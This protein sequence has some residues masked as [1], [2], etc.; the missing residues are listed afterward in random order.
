MGG[1]FTTS[2]IWVLSG[3]LSKT[4]LDVRLWTL[5]VVAAI[6]LL[7]EVGAI[8]LATPT[9][10][11]M[12]PQSRFWDSR[13]LGSLWFGVE[14]GLGFRTR[15]YNFGPYLLAVLVLLLSPPFSAVVALSSGWA[16]GH[17][18]A[19]VV[20]LVPRVRQWEYLDEVYDEN[21]RYDR[22]LN[23]VAGASAKLTALGIL[24]VAFV[25]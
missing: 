19:L 25:V 8:R 23:A 1:L 12:I 7:R 6:A 3:L 20:R 2:F 11:Y 17:S 14:L 21:S 9:T 4:S 13:T 16:I 10:S 24:A 18:W 15:I 5:G 22:I